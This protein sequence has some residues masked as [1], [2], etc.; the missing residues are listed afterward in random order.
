[1]EEVGR[2][3][4]T[5]FSSMRQEQREGGWR[6]EEG[7]GRGRV[8]DPMGARGT[9]QATLETFPVTP[10]YKNNPASSPTQAQPAVSTSV[11]SGHL[12]NCLLTSHPELFK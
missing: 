6:E 2:M 7:M 12:L 10:P 4:H 3:A 9:L 5:C 11:A 1:M 8:L